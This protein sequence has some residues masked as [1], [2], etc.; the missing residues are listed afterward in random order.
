MKTKAKLKKI[1]KNEAKCCWPACDKL[2]SHKLL[3]Q[4]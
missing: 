3:V 4:M 1:N 2:D